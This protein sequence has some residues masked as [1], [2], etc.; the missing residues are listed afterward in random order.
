MR[1]IP[2]YVSFTNLKAF[3]DIY[4]YSLSIIKDDFYS[5]IASNNPS[6]AQILSR[7]EYSRKRRFIS[8]VFLP[9][10]VTTIEPRVIIIVE[11]LLRC[12]KIKATGSIV[13]LTDTYPIV[14]G[15]FNLQPQLNM[16]SYDTITSIFQSSLYGKQY[17]DL[18]RLATNRF[19]V[20]S[21]RVTISVQL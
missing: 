18:R 19:Q 10:E 2:S 6:I 13:A 3:R 20:F 21:T 12:L 4:S 17:R 9:R 8:Y 1:L 11:K 5:H 15:A 7:A 14:D 16:F